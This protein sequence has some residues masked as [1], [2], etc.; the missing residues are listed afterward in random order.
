MLLLTACWVYGQIG[1]HEE[2]LEEL[3]DADEI[4]YLSPDSDNVLETLDPACVYVVGGIVDRS[5]RKVQKL[6]LSRSQKLSFC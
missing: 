3:Y 2:P 5:V 1:R 4:V 6:Q